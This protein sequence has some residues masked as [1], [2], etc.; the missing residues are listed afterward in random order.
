MSEASASDEWPQSAV[1]RRGVLL[2]GTAIAAAG[3]APAALVGSAAAE[4]ATGARPN[5]VFILAD[6][7]GYG[8]LGSLRRRRTARRADAAGSIRWRARD[9]G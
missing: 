2:A 4:E 1:S 3:L 7:V 6:N 9:C 5:V 8:D